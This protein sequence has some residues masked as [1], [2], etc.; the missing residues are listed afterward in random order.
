MSEQARQAKREAA[1][2]RFFELGKA[3]EEEGAEPLQ[4]TDAFAT[5]IPAELAEH[6]QTERVLP[7]WRRALAA[8]LGPRS[9]HSNNY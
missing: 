4:W 3:L 9:N 1:Y 7:A 2:A 8:L 5:G 6:L